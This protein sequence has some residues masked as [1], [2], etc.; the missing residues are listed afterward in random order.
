MGEATTSGR[1]GELARGIPV[2]AAALI[3]ILPLPLAGLALLVSRPRWD[4]MYRD[5]PIHFWIVLLA[6]AINVGLGLATSET[7]RKWGDP[8]LFLV[9]MALLTSAG[10]LGL[11]ALATPR[12]LLPG[13][14]TGFVVANPIG[15][16]LAAGFAAGSAL[17]LERHGAAVL[18]WRG[19][20]RAALGLVVAAWA[21][22]S[23]AGLPPLGETV[24]SQHLPAGIG[25]IGIPAL[26]LYGFACAR[27]VLLYRRRPRTLLLAVAVAYALLA[28]A[29]TAVVFSRTWHVTWWEWHVLM[30]ASFATIALGARLEYRR[31]R[32]LGG[33]FGGLYLESTLERIDRR[34]ADALGELVAALRSDEPLSPILERARREWATAEEAALLER[35][36]R[37]LRRVDELFRPYVSPQLARGLEERPELASLGGEQRE[38]TVLFADLEGFTSF[39]ERHQ[40]DEV[41]SMLNT[42]WSAAV[43]VVA[44]REGGLIERFAGDA[45][46]VVFNAV[47]EQ[48]DHAARGAR[49]A[50]GLRD[51][52]DAIAR[53]HPDWPRFRI[54]VNTGPAVVGNVGA[55]GMRSFTAIGDTTNVSA[56]LQAVA[57]T[58]EIVISGSTLAGLGPEARAEPIGDLELKGRS[59]PVATF[60]LVAFSD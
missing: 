17:G 42:Y 5:D 22:V 43:P 3:V 1:G 13:S 31:E 21:A 58:G 38:V 60:R 2:R 50:I 29:M 34:H 41:I 26:A 55:S 23:L 37:Q 9:S 53:T 10:F 47:A 16:F 25:L 28:E 24:P 51:E 52:A 35:S 39:S 7:A 30:A 32:S 14:N 59:E 40:P 46:L 4:V 8:R 33:A 12:V 15:L 44:E 36:A 11:H 18:R 48:A 19:W 57:R 49:A 56:R 20:I 45:I 6:A 27:Y 54:G